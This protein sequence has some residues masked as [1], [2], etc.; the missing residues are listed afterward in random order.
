MPSATVAESSDSIEPSNAKEIAAGSISM[1]RDGERSGSDGNG[2]VCG[3]PPN[4]VPMVATGRWNSAVAAAAAPTAMSMPGQCGRNDRR[5]TITRIV[6]SARAN[7]VGSSVGKAFQS[8]G[9]LSRSGPGSG[10]DKVRP[11]RSEIWL[12]KMMTA[13][14]AV[15]P[16]VTG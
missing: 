7:V 5:P 4:F 10:P 8:A 9:N 6:P 11:R 15:K 2:T 1:T 3:M 12:E 16:T 14:P 13:M